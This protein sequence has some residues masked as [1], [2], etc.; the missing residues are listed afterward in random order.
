MVTVIPL[1]PCR[2]LTKT[3]DFYRALG[4]EVTHEQETPY[5]YGAVQRG[6]VQLHFSHLTVYGA[7]GAFGAA[8]VF[9]S[10]VFV[11]HRAF[12]EG[13][14]TVYGSVPTADFPR[15]T[16]LK[17]GHTRFTVFDPVGNMITYIN[18]NEPDADYASDDT[19]SD[20]ERVLDNAFFLRDTYANDKAAAHTLDKAIKRYADA[21]PLERGRLLAARA[22]LA[23][24]MGEREQ[25]RALRD[26][27]AQIV[28][29]EADREQYRDELQAADEI[30][31]W[32]GMKE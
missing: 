10:D 24:A 14:R 3:L 20:I 5:A 30:E 32:M 1:L 22:E 18:S 15:L 16:R 26:A 29:S 31:R 7:K 4:F 13:L 28:L 25:A 23:L 8:L 11:E 17:K 12:S 9:V 19:L 6:D 2:S 27:L 21:A